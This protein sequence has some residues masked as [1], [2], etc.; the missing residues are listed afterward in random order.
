[1]FIGASGSRASLYVLLLMRVTHRELTLC[2]HRASATVDVAPVFS[3]DSQQI[4]FHSDRH[5]KTA[6]YQMRVDRLVEKTDT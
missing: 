6:I 5:G 2:E 4:F 3:Y 1:M